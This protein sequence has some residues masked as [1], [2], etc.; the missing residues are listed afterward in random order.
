MS[1]KVSIIT[2]S[3][4]AEQT[5][6]K[7]MKSVLIQS[8]R[9]LE[10]ILVD[11]GSN[12]GTVPLIQKYIPIFH[13][14][15]IEI[16]FKAEPDKGISDAFNKGIKRSSGTIIGIINADDQLAENALSIVV[17]R[18]GDQ[19]SVLCGDCMWVDEKN[20]FSYIRKSRMQLSRLKYD[21]VIMH[22][23][24][25]VKKSAYEKYGC[26][27]VSMKYVMDKDLMSRFYRMGAKFTYI[28]EVLAIMY[29]GGIS[30]A[31]SKLVFEEGI[32]VASRNGVPEWKARI[33]SYFKFIR[34]R[35]ISLMKKRQIIWKHLK[36]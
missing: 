12:D 31:N 6:E 34:M 8:Y 4:N 13:S 30:D 36:R 26:F 10:Y 1:E 2:I 17:D 11:G 32:T 7:T 27:D 5:I 16:D 19:Y 21:M 24:C 25:F 15:G 3:F 14:A 33:Y 22:P 9:P 28:P 35:V 20:G 29:A 23:T 18:F